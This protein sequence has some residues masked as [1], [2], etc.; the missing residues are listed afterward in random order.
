MHAHEDELKGVHATINLDMVGEHPVTVGGPMN[1]T[2]APDSTPSYLNALLIGMLEDVA[3]DTRGHSL[4]GWPY[5]LNYRVKGYS[6]GSDHVCFAD[7]AFGIPSVMFGSA[8]QFHHTSFDE[9]SRV[10]STRLKRVG[11]MTGGAALT[12]ACAGDDAAIE[13]AAQTHAYAHKRISGTTSRLTSEL[14]NADPED[15]DYAERLGTRYVR[16]LA[17]LDEAGRREVKAVTASQKLADDGSTY[18][19]GLSA[20]VKELAE[21]QKEIVKS[22]YEGLAA[23]AAVELMEREAGAVEETM[24]LIPKKTYAGPTRGIRADEIEDEED[25]KWFRANSRGTPL[26]RT[27]LEL[28]NFVDGKRSVYDIAIAISMEYHD[29]DP[30]DVKRYLDIYKATGKITYA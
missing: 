7:Q 26:G 29:I 13:L 3:D 16:G 9:V 24:K 30:L 8:D 22:L 23:K 28:M 14:L 27:T 18:I 19:E 20:R 6:G 21:A 17:M 12:I 10:D 25:R 4:E 1:L 2:C 15:A 11:V 5:G